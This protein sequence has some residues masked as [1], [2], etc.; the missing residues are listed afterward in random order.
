MI[1]LE[2][3]KNFNKELFV[4]NIKFCDKIHFDRSRSLLERT[5]EIDQDSNQENLFSVNLENKGASNQK[6]SQVYTHLISLA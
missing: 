4:S 5:I 3:A 1:I 2:Y 6:D